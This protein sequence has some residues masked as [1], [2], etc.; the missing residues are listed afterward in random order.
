LTLC[1]CFHE[2]QSDTIF[3]RTNA[4]DALSSHPVK[5]PAALP[6]PN[7]VRSIS[8][9]QHL[10]EVKKSIQVK[11]GAAAASNN[12]RVMLGFFLP[13]PMP[14]MWDIRHSSFLKRTAQE[15]QLQQCCIEGHQQRGLWTFIQILLFISPNQNKAG[16]Q[17]CTRVWVMILAWRRSR[18]F[19]RKILSFSEFTPF[20]SIWWAQNQ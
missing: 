3:E 1:V 10:C 8:W 14:C 16:S 19:S 17:T 12:K 5:M 4:G 20:Y 11:S 2:K 18:I 13:L 9:A 6:I 7:T 15:S